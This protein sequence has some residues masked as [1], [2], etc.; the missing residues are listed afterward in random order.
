MPA[1][2]AAE[3]AQRQASSCEHTVTRSSVV[4]ARSMCSWQH[5]RWIWTIQT[6]QTFA[7]Q[8]YPGGLARPRPRLQ[9]RAA[10]TRERTREGLCC[11]QSGDCALVTA[12]GNYL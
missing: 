11:S 5:N 10:A 3:L 4:L 6:C 2:P 8:W 12:A 7:R 1:S 9:R